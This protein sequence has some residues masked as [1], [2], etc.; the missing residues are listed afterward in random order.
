MLRQD[1]DARDAISPLYWIKRV[2]K[3]ETRAT[4]SA[5]SSCVERHYRVLTVNMPK[6]YAL[7][8][9]HFTVNPVKCQQQ[10]KCLFKQTG[11]AHLTLKLLRQGALVRDEHQAALC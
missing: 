5:S 10:N 8:H 3:E 2:A 7:C 9:L 1:G 6:Q 11:V 4:K